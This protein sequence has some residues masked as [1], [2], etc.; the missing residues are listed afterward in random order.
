MPERVEVAEP[1]DVFGD[2]LLPGLFACQDVWIDVEYINNGGRTMG[3][4]FSEGFGGVLVGNAIAQKHNLPIGY[5]LRV[6]LPH[7]VGADMLLRS[8][9]D[10]THQEG[11]TP[12]PLDLHFELSA[13][14][15]SIARKYI[16]GGFEDVLI[17]LASS[18]IVTM[19][20]DQIM[21]GPLQ[22]ETTLSIR[23]L[24]MVF[25]AVR[26]FDPQ[27]LLDSDAQAYEGD[28]AEFCYFCGFTVAP[29]TTHCPSCSSE[30]ADDE[31]EQDD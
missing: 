7:E 9:S 24:E 6:W 11:S 27:A 20:D 18:Y 28:D 26:S 29:G 5:Y 14:C 22:G 4:R 17:A 1:V 31:D 15:E 30:L 21:F 12:S 16:A 25:A 19:R 23:A 13:G 10:L 3:S 2:K 8:R